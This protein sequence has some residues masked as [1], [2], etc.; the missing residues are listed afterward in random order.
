[1]V[2][3]W[4]HKADCASILV[5]LVALGH[6][7]YQILTPELDR[8][9]PPHTAPACWYSPP[10]LFL[11]TLLFHA[12]ICMVFP[13]CS[14]WLNC[15]L[16]ISPLFSLLSF[17]LAKVHQSFKIKVVYLFQ[18]QGLGQLSL[19]SRG[20]KLLPSTTQIDLCCSIIPLQPVHLSL[21]V[22]WGIWIYRTGDA[23]CPQV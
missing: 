8:Y 1:M 19:T 5:G 16:F 9:G 18:I 12:P 15:P 2:I 23:R 21:A 22:S 10:L 7:W 13:Y 17:S 4:Y 6:L 3:L 20:C 11:M 14:L